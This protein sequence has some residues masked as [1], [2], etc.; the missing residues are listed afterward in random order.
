MN[1]ALTLDP[2]SILESLSP[3]G[4]IALIAMP[5]TPF[6]LASDTMFRC[7]ALSGS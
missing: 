3:Y 7:T 6:L 1:L 2:K 5:L 4:E